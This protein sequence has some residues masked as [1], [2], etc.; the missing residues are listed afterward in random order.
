[1]FVHHKTFQ[2]SLMFVGKAWSLPY[3]GA[4]ERFFTLG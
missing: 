3:N 1:V 4:L 2:S